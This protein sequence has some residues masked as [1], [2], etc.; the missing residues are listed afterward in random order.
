MS[1]NNV[2]SLTGRVLIR[3]SSRKHSVLPKVRKWRIAAARRMV[4]ASLYVVAVCVNRIGTL[5]WSLEQYSS[6][7]L[8]R[9]TRPMLP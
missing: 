7:F 9:T 2:V 4:T 5:S 6:R 3:N 8:A 1:E